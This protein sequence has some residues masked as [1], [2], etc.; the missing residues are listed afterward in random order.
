MAITTSN[1]LPPGTQ[2]FYDRNL[3]RRAQ[4]AAVFDRYGQK[5]PLAQ[6]S[7]NQIKFR[8]YSQL[9]PASTPLVEGIT[10]SGSQLTATDILAQI[11]Q[12]GD[13]V[14]LS[15]L[16]SM[17][18]QDPIVTEATDV[19]GDQAGTTIDQARRDVLVTG[20]NV[21]Y[22]GGVQTR[23]QVA[24]KITGPDLDRAIRALKNQNAKFMKEGMMASDKVG[25][26]AVRKAFIAVVPPDVEFD[27]ETMLG[28]R[29]VSDYGS[30]DGVMEDEIGAYKNVR[31][32]STTSSKVF[33]G[34]GAAG[35]TLYKN[36]NGAYD[37]YPVLIFGADAYGVI[38]LAG[39]GMSTYVKELG[40]SGAAD[41]LNQRSTVGWKADTTTKI[42]NE[43]WIIRLEVAASL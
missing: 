35:T 42:L 21:V 12:Y 7:G 25:T 14:T 16:V 31:F 28:Y 34:A 29:S 40:S 18:N 1:S 3:L 4:P 27:M 39:A 24:T 10:P 5:R 22:A 43:A 19:L 26:A 17:T 41:P 15:D 8:R 11:Q 9:A 32:V 38:D 33:P 23:G 37:V 13:Y 20:T 30:M 6:R 36:T 2:A